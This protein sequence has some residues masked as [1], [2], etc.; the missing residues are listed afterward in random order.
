MAGVLTKRVRASPIGLARGVRTAIA[1]V[2]G[3]RVSAELARKLH[4]APLMITAAML[5]LIQETGEDVLVLVETIDEDEF[6]RSRLTRAEAQRLLGLMAATLADLPDVVH[7]AMPEIDWA[8]W[9]ALSGPIKGTGDEAA[10]VAW[11][12][13]RSLVPATLSWLRVYKQAEPQL[14]VF[15]A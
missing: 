3:A 15:K 8:G 1:Q 12:G 14:F 2:D 5:K 6:T 11:F 4:D 9:R 10:Q 7:Q 13:A